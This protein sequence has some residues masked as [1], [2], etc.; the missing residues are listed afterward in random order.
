MKLIEYMKDAL[1]LILMVLKAY[2]NSSLE[3][4]TW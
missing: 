2:Q 1:G 3:Y 4:G